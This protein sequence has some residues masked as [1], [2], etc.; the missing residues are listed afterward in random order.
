MTPVYSGGLIYQFTSEK[1]METFGLVQISQD[2]ST[3][4]TLPEFNVLKSAFSQATV[5]GDGGYRTDVKASACPQTDNVWRANTSLP[6]MP[7]G[8]DQYV[9]NGAGT[10]PGNKDPKG[11]HWAGTPSTGWVKIDQ[12]TAGSNDSHTG[13]SSSGASGTPVPTLAISLI[14]LGLVFGL[15]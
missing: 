10:P 11:S 3:A 12:S 14:L 4:Q 9:K 8:A 1:G 2:G 15:C 13:P 5:P 6:I 7:K